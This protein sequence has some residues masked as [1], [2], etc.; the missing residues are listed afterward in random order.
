MVSKTLIV[1]EKYSR[2]P[3]QTVSP[4]H[5]RPR[6][7]SMVTP[8]SR[9][10]QRP[11]ISPEMY[12]LRSLSEASRFRNWLMFRKGSSEMTTRGWD[13]RKVSDFSFFFVG[14]LRLI[15]EGRPWIMSTTSLPTSVEAWLDEVDDERV[16]D[17]GWDTDR[18]E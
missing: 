6:S 4:G 12:F 5:E 7:F 13:R 16:D 15:T 14:R 1:S 10:T 17:E 9:M 3:S 18:E 11:T 8:H 2:N